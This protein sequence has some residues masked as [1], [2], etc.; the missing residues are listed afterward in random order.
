M[1]LSTLSAGSSNTNTNTNANAATQ[2]RKPA[3]ISWPWFILMC[4]MIAVI[5]GNSMVPGDDSGGISL[6]VLA[7]VQGALGMIGLPYEW[8]TNFIIRKVAH[9]TEYLVLALI[10]MQALR[11]HRVSAQGLS[12]KKR[13]VL[14]ITTAAILIVVPSIDEGVIQRFIGVNRGPALRDVIIDCC[15]AATGALLTVLVSRL[16]AHRGTRL[17]H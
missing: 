16:R 13:L 2:A 10:A 11:P 5:W 17:Q 15:G 6:T 12:R 7:W 1:S 3:L 4:L 8:L 14:A 9:F